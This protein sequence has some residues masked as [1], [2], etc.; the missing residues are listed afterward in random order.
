MSCQRQTDL[1]LLINAPRLSGEEVLPQ[2]KTY[3]LSY[4]AK[5]DV[6]DKVVLSWRCSGL[7][8]KTFFEMKEL[9]ARLPLHSEMVQLSLIL[10][11]NV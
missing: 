11:F 4:H 2:I 8:Y 1:I 7:Y 10:L 9:L 3:L 6:D 5:I